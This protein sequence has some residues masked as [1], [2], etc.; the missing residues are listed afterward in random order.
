[1]PFGA[2]SDKDR[3]FVMQAHK[4]GLTITLLAFV[5]LLGTPVRAGTPYEE[6]IGGLRPA[7][8]LAARPAGRARGRC[9]A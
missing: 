1:M 2:D 8:S 4:P 7:P 3:R 6:Q 5:A 9:V